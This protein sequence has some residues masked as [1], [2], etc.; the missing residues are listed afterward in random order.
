ML[1]ALNDAQSDVI[2]VVCIA[3]CHSI[4]VERLALFEDRSVFEPVLLEYKT[5][6]AN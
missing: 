2:R 4:R 3:D 5:A 1:L 6:E